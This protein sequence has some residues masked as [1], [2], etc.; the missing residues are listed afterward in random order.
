[1]EALVKKTKNNI[2]P[3]LSMSIPRSKKFWIITT[4]VVIILLVVFSKSRG[5]KTPEFSHTSV[6]RTELVQSVSET[7]SISGE[8]DI[9]YG[10]EVSGRVAQ[11]SKKSG[12]TVEKG[13]LIAKLQNVQQRSALAQSVAQL[14]SAQASLDLRIAGASDAE[15]TKALALVDQKR[16]SLDKTEAS[17]ASTVDTAKKEFSDAE[18][19]LKLVEAGEDSKIVRDAYDD[20]INTLKSTMASLSDA[21]TE[22]DNIIGIDNATANDVFEDGLGSASPGTLFTAETSYKKARS[23]YNAAKAGVFALQISSPNDKV[24]LSISPTQNT[25]AQ[26]QSHLVDMQAMLTASRAVL[27]MT[28]SNLETLKSDINAALVSVNTASTNLTNS[29]QAVSSAKNSLAGYEIAYNKAKN[30]LENKKK[31]AEADIKIAKADLA[32]AQAAYDLL[33]AA[34]RDVDLGSLRADVNR[35]SASVQSAQNEVSK[36]ELR[37][38][39]DGVVAKLDVNV[40]ENVTALDPVITLVS[41]EKSIEVDIS[42]SDVA[43]VSVDDDVVITLDA[44]GDDVELM[45][46]VVSVEPGKT[47]VSGVIYYNTDILLSDTSDLPIR[48]GMTANVEI[49]TETKE[50]VLVAPQ[51]SII[52]ES[53]KKYIRVL[54]NKTK[55]KFDKKEVETGLRGN[56][57]LIEITSGVEEGDEIITFIKEN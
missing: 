56:G 57:G 48:S 24:D 5:D 10:W 36:T 15:R 16:A 25:V 47:E 46:K 31:Q 55:G 30:N 4:I 6:E 20:L 33:V 32:Q 18:N 17:S 39:A 40:G 29:V 34:P 8:L 53:G 51:R 26:I 12:D 23:A 19:D 45:G 13:D 14:R 38:I 11:I 27:G 2:I 22:S 44:F 3:H 49:I 37:A 28:E 52:N 41:P 54:T 9:S 35:Y 7:G 50:G 42:E 1:M 21:L 43:K